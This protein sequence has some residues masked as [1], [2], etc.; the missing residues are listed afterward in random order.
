MECKLSKI[1]RRVSRS[2]H[3]L[4]LLPF[5]DYKTPITHATNNGPHLP[6]K[7]NEIGRIFIFELRIN[8]QAIKL[9]GSCLNQT[10]LDWKGNLER[11]I[12]TIETARADKV[13]VLCLPELC[14]SGYGCEDAF[15]SDA[16][17]ERSLSGLE[18][19]MAA[20]KGMAVSVGLPLVYENC[21][22]NCAAL[23]F[24][25][26]LLGIYAKNELAGDGI[27]YEPRWFKPWPDEAVVEYE[28]RGKAYPFGDTAFEIGG[29]RIGFEICEDAWNGVRPAQ[30]HYLNNVDV[31]LN[32]S[33]SHFSFGKTRLRRGLVVEASR[34][35]ACAY[36]YSNLLGV[37]SGRI[38]YDGEI[39]IAQ[40]GK[41][42]AQNRRFSFKDY[43]I[44]TA[45]VDLDGPRRARKKLFSFR[46]NV[47]AEV[48]I[49]EGALPQ[50]R[51]T[52][53]AADAVAPDMDKNE[54]IYRSLTLALFDY[55]RKSYSRGFVLSLSGG[56]DSSACAV[57]AARAITEARNE[58]GEEEFNRK[59]AY[60]RDRS[61]SA[62]LMCVYQATKNSSAATEES[63]RELAGELGAAFHRWSV[64][65]LINE[66]VG[67]AETAVGRK[68]TW[69]NDDIALQNIQAR[70]R[71]PGVWMLA[72]VYGALL[73][74]TSNRSE[75]AVGYATMDGDTAGGLAPLGGLDKAA[76][77]EWLR[78]AEKQLDLP[79]LRYVNGLRPSAELRPL[80]QDQTDEDD[81]MPYPILDAIERCAIH[82]YKSPLDTFLTLRGIVDDERLKGYVRK[83]FVLWSRN[84]WKR[85][86]Y[87]PSFH[88]DDA[89]L[90]PRTW[91]RFPILSGGF[92]EEL[93][94]LDRFN[95]QKA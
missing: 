15:F 56:A 85:E 16:V 67:K 43:Q 60:L 74:T 86:R 12:K 77:L 37:E 48:V 5:F 46:P 88:L 62:L 23:V 73:L 68:M 66:Y 63:A 45:T 24:D 78:W 87:A 27:H 9:A 89:N 26:K 54:E 57:L 95:A 53:P 2:I 93:D 70:V 65:E 91:C 75:A 32:P 44:L 58:L 38:V 42:L 71:A 69:E 39:I 28:W 40:S 3:G 64:D 72:N 10:P 6:G 22:Y 17:V 18:K 7:Q 35:Y 94:E 29:V 79:A 4:P 83:F 50:T 25:K 49:A 92:A 55:M 19:V 21:L 41:L 90:D 51:Y 84:Q 80:E 30:R 76:L 61:P 34:S 81:L 82:E 36:V 31:I 13:A 52:P 20:S 1:G 59:T 8:M 14:L 11:I 47:T 33:A